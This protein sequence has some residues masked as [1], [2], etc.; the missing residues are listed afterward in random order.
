[1][2]SIRLP[3]IA[4]KNSLFFI[5]VAKCGRRSI[6]ACGGAAGF[7]RRSI[8][9]ALLTLPA[10]E[11]LN[12]NCVERKWCPLCEEWKVTTVKV[13]DS[14]DSELIASTHEMIYCPECGALLR[15]EPE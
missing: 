2:K 8:R 9:D 13:A 5:G 15:D 14:L 6:A 7:F 4:A 12:G 11:A 10:H 1:M 3:I